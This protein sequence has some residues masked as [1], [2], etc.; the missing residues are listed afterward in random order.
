MHSKYLQLIH[1]ASLDQRCRVVSWWNVDGRL[2]VREGVQRTWRIRGERRYFLG[3]NITV[4]LPV[5]REIPVTV[6]YE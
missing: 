3:A 6:S 4:E 2:V 5:L 1:C